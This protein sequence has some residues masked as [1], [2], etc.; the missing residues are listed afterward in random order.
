MI[1]STPAMVLSITVVT[2]Q[3]EMAEN[4][5]ESLEGCKRFEHAGAQELGSTTSGKNFSRFRKL[6]RVLSRAGLS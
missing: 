3:G 6:S 4:E 2:L 5:E 1:L